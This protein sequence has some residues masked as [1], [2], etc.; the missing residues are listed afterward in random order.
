MKGGGM[1]CLVSRMR[2]APSTPLCKGGQ[3]GFFLVKV[4][5]DSAVM[6]PYGEH[7]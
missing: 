3:G 7:N 5:W 2:E 4:P 1:V 6:P